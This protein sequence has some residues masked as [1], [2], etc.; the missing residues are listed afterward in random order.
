M[1]ILDH[2]ELILRDFMGS[3]H[4]I[5]EAARVSNDNAETEVVNPFDDANTI[6]Y[7]MDNRHTTPFEMVEFKFYVKAPIFVFRQWHRH[8]T[9]NYNEVSARYT[10]LPDEMF[11]PE[12][13]TIGKQSTSNKQARTLEQLTPKERLKLEDSLIEY[14]TGLQASYQLYERLNGFY[15]WPRELARAVL[16]FAIYSKM[17]AK[18]DLHN[19]FHFIGLR[20]HDHAQHEV[21]VYARGMLELIRP[22]VPEACKAYERVINYRNEFTQYLALVRKAE[23]DAD[24]KAKST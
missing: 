3:D 17:Y 9:W 11:I 21:Q 12:L 7:L 2:G 6:R 13:M 8:R 22:V 16:P 5:A 15:E 18:V 19:L 1:D 23:R 24:K 10:Q 4:A 14:Q 20:D